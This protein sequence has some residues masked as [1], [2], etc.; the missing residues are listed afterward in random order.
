MAV[1]PAAGLARG[2]AQVSRDRS[3]GAACPDGAAASGPV[4]VLACAYSGAGRLRSLLGRHP[5]LACTSGTGILPLCEQAMAAW[6]SADSQAA[7][8]A[9]PLAVT[10]TRA[11][12]SSI[13]TSLLAR[14]GKRRWCEIAAANAQTAETFLRVYPATKFLCLYRACPGV[15]RAALDA[16]PWGLAD[17]VFVPFT[18]AH[19]VSTVAGLTAYWVAHTRS[20]LAFEQSHHQA[21]Q[22]V[23]F[24]DLTAHQ[25]E[26]AER[27]TSFLDIAG[28]DGRAPLA[29]DNPAQPESDSIRS[30]ARFPADLIPPTMLAQANDLLQQLGYAALPAASAGWQLAPQP[31]GAARSLAP[32]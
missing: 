10:A 3:E 21:C 25:H 31:Q 22:R 19:P 9:S 28:L 13:I 29:E 32:A 27:I 8:S 4:I 26:T 14:D 20:L 23:R 24:E 15:I 17:P 12:A 11:M 18:Q 2:G 1:A 16:A 5:D 6:R 30:E 7:R